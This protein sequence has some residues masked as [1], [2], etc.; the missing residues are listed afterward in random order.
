MGK[1]IKEF[2]ISVDI[3]ADGPC[4]LVNSMLQLGAVF[5]TPDGKTITEYS[6]NIKEIDGAVRDKGTMKWWADQEVKFPGIWERMMKNRIPAVDA[7]ERF[8]KA[9]K[10]VEKETGAK[11]LVVAYPA[12]YDFTWLYVYLCKFLGYSPVGFSALDMKTLA[13]ALLNK[14]YHDSAKKRFPK[15]WFDPSLKH[16]HFALDDAHEQKYI[17]LQMMKT[18]QKTENTTVTS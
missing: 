15:E 7:M 16:T 2:Y 18:L 5:Y 17:H 4:P 3:E 13:M 11:P 14:S 10:Q 1:H 9:V 6:A 12:C 8:E